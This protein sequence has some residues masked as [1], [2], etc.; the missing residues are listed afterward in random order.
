VT[1]QRKSSTRIGTAEREAA[2]RALQEHLNAGR[3]QV[4]EYAERS[5]QAADATTASE[6]A[7]LFTD[8]P[9]P[10]PKLPGMA[11]SALGR[12]V[13][14]P[15]VVGA[16]VLAVAAV[17]LVVGFSVRG[18]PPSPPAPQPG[19]TVRALP[20]VATSAPVSRPTTSATST[21]SPDGTGG[22]AAVL[23]NGVDVRRTTGTDVIT[24]RP[25]YGVDLD[26]NTSSN[27][28]VANTGT[29]YG[30]DVGSGSDGNSL[31][32]T[33]DYAVV[34]S[35]PEYATCARETGYTRGGIER[36]SLHS[37]DNICVR[38]D[39]DRYALV[40]IVAA[41]EQAMQFRAVV[42]DPVVPS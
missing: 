10:R 8:L 13:R 33:R 36:G 5:A 22:T 21:A 9:A 1:T 28:A 23:P 20:P 2:Q 30:R 24:L 37:G 29:S 7:V 6:I 27:W 42:W 14:N 41:D 26:N 3:L 35:V 31:Y 4:N 19:P 25:S 12:M 40:T 32:F 18:I 16:T 39:Q 38:T 17:A 11:N 15:V 34:T